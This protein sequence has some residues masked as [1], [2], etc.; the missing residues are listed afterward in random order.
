M[1]E[2]AEWEGGI[3]ELGG[4]NALC[5]GKGVGIVFGTNS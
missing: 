3:E 4:K 2:G 5:L 1:W